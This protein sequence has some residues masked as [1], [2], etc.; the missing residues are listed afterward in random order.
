MINIYN[1]LLLAS[2]IP[3]CFYIWK[4]IHYFFMKKPLT[5]VSG[6]QIVPVHLPKMF[7]LPHI[8]IMISSYLILLWRLTSMNFFFGYTPL[9]ILS[10]LNFFAFWPSITHI[11]TIHGLP[12]II[13]NIVSASINLIFAIVPPYPITQFIQLLLM[14]IESGFFFQLKPVLTQM[15]FSI[16][17]YLN[18]SVVAKYNSYSIKFNNDI[19]FVDFDGLAKQKINFMDVYTVFGKW[20]FIPSIVYR[21]TTKILYYIQ[22]TPLDFGSDYDV[23]YDNLIKTTEEEFIIHG[24]ST[25]PKLNGTIVDTLVLNNYNFNNS[26]Y[27]IYIKEN[28]I[29]KLVSAEGKIIYKGDFVYEQH[30]KKACSG[31]IIYLNVFAHLAQ[32]HLTFQNQLLNSAVYLFRDNTFETKE[33]HSLFVL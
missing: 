1:Y 15:I 7:L 26:G 17:F 19:K 21:L 8:L 29:R 28:E 30:L 27:L 31:L 6:N 24:S 9:I 2:Y 14:N 20:V 22:T 18:E 32:F 23:W 12:A 10:I 5:V 33:Y 11:L 3:L 13:L 4:F 25:L 16:G